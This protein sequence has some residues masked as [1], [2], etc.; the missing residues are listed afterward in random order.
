MLPS[1]EYGRL[2]LRAID[3]VAGG[4]RRKKYRMT[5]LVPGMWPQSIVTA[6]FPVGLP[7]GRRRSVAMVHRSLPLISRRHRH[8]EMLE[9]PL[10]AL[11]WF[12]LILVAFLYTLGEFS[13]LFGVLY[14]TVPWLWM[15][16][17]AGR[18]VFHLLDFIRAGDPGC[19][20]GLD[21]LLDGAGQPAL[22]VES[23]PFLKWVAIFCA[24]AVIV[25]DVF[26]Q[27]SLGIWTCLSLLLIIASCAWFFRLT[28]RPAPASL[29]VFLAAF[30]LFD[31]GVFNWLEFNKN[32]LAKSGDEY[33]QVVTLRQASDFVKA[34]P[35]P[36]RVRV[37][38][39][40]APNIGDIL[41]RTNPVGRRR[42]HDHRVLAIE[43]ARRD[44]LQRA[45][46]H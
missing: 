14:A 39:S 8:L 16:R 26:N 38:A 3:G 40:P 5:A 34:Q 29:R 24:A 17:A 2:S 36:N 37:S 31:L 18:F 32:Q 4:P 44:L 45:L 19:I 30:I 25:P 46:S 22:W 10:G 21:S 23:R 1:V 20:F 28:L 42:D 41:W 43:P 11:L 7:H 9:K 12:F 33:V 15:L 6:L 13:P 35:G 27:I